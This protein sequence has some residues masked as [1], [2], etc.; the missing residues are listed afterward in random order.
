MQTKMRNVLA[1]KWVFT[2]NATFASKCSN[3]KHFIE[4]PAY[5]TSVIH[6]LSLILF[7]CH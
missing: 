7:S 4:P 1:L 2:E 5:L 3:H 6:P